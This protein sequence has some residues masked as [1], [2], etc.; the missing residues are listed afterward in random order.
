[1]RNK[2]SAVFKLFSYIVV[3]DKVANKVAGKCRMQKTFLISSDGYNNTLLNDI[4]KLTTDECFNK[5]HL[6]YICNIWRNIF[7]T[8]A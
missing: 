6:K 4:T 7:C 2:D 8:L 3:S 1:M 5:V